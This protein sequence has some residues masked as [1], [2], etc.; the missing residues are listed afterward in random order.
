MAVAP[1]PTEPLTI[2]I[3]AVVLIKINKVPIVIRPV[4]PVSS[5]ELNIR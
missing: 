3:S 5:G 2:C 1:V 4:S